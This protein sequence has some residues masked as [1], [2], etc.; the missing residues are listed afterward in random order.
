MKLEWVYGIRSSDTRKS[1]QYT[2]GQVSAATKSEL[3]LEMA[4]E[5]RSEEEIIYYTGCV[6]ILLNT[7]VNKQRFYL[8]HDQ[9]VI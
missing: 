8:S 5:K 6:V 1:L 4:E 7:N 9:E 3:T 2:V